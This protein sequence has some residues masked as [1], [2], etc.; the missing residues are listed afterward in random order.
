MKKLKTNVSLI[1]LLIAFVLFVSSCGDAKQ[2][3]SADGTEEGSAASS[4]ANGPAP[5]IVEAEMLEEA[6]II[7]LWSKLSVKKTPSSKGKWI[8]NIYLG[9]AATYKGITVTD[10]TVA[11]G[12]EYAKIELIDGTKGWVDTR[13]MAIDAKPYVIKE[14]SKLYKRPVLVASSDKEFARMQF[15][16]V[17]EEKEGWSKVKGK[18]SED[19][20]FTDGWV[21]SDHLTNNETDINVAILTARALEAKTEEKQKEALAEIVNN[22]DLNTSAFI[23]DIQEMLVEQSIEE[24]DSATVEMQN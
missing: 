14:P 12:K 7:S 13:F 11:K 17:L 22:S 18:R 3:T 15:V 8:T 1:A 10:T 21:K 20:W 4:P 5:Q 2:E 16:V 23:P 6:P 24:A 19:S 9:E